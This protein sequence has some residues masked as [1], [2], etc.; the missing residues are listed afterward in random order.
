M[1]LFVLHNPWIDTD[2]LTFRSWTTNTYIWNTILIVLT[3]QISISITLVRWAL[4]KVVTYSHTS[5]L[6]IWLRD[7]DHVAHLWRFVYIGMLMLLDQSRSLI[8]MHR[9]T[10]WNQLRLKFVSL[11]FV[12]ITF[13]WTYEVPNQLVS[14]LVK[15]V[16]FEG[17][18]VRIV[19]LK[20]L[21]LCELLKL[22]MQAFTDLPAHRDVK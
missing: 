9:L 13:S 6:S 22:P 8:I 3:V 18:S 5:L 15:Q 16:N 10:V 17:G 2:F 7:Q 14:V 4:D 20:A 11:L 12:F 21:E 1:I 19:N